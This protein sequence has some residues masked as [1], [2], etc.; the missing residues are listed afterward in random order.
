MVKAIP[1]GY[2][3]VT[4]SIITSDASEFI[5]FLGSAFGAE[6]RL[7]MPMPDGKV[8]HAEV[9][10]G[11]API[12]VADAMEGYPAMSSFI[13]LYVEDVDATHRKAVAAG[14][15]S[16]RGP[17]DRFYGDRSAEL[18]DR[19]GNRWSIATHVKDVSDEDMMSA[20]ES[21]MAQA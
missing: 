20:M 11:G 10:I 19:W 4:P 8:A 7:R 21:E 14:C 16:E 1:D 3:S 12:M 15:T 9:T 5:A 18:H 17:E 6:E 13:H 2:S